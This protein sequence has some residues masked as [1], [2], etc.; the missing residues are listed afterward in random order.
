M[1]QFTEI[2]DDNLPELGECVALRL[3]NRGIVLG[4]REEDT[5][6]GELAWFWNR[7]YGQPDWNAKTGRWES[8]SPEEDDLQPTHFARLPAWEESKS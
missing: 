5:Y 8:D 3:K 7:E 4:S 1:N 6:D 2:T